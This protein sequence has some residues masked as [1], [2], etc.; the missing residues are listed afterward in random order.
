MH[1]TL[2]SLFDRKMEAD[3]KYPDNFYHLTLPNRFKFF[4]NIWNQEA[5]L[6]DLNNEIPTTGN[7]SI[8]KFARMLQSNGILTI[9]DQE[10]SKT[11]QKEKFFFILKKILEIFTI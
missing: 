7:E 5:F 2:M 3:Q 11:H 10:N 1:V 9:I 8:W 6:N 4:I